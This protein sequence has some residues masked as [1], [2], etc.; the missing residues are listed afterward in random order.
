MISKNHYRLIRLFSLFYLIVCFILSCRGEA[1][2]EQKGLI[3][4]TLINGQR[5][6]KIINIGLVDYSQ[7]LPLV[8]ANGGMETAENSDVSAANLKFQFSQ[9][10]DF[11]HLLKDLINQKIDIAI[12]PYWNVFD[13]SSQLVEKRITVFAITGF[14][15]GGYKGLSTEVSGV[16]SV[17]DLSGKRISC[18]NKSVAAAMAKFQLRLNSISPDDVQWIY[19]KNDTEALAAL[20]SGDADAVFINQATSSA[21]SYRTIAS[22][23][24]WP[25]LM[26]FVVVAGERWLITHASEAKSITDLVIANGRDMQLLRKKY[27]QITPLQQIVPTVQLSSFI[28]AF[29]YDFAAFF[30]LDDTSAVQALYID[31]LE[32]YLPEGF[33][34]KRQYLFSSHINRAFVSHLQINDFSVITSGNHDSFDVCTLFVPIENGEPKNTSYASISATLLRIIP[35]LDS[36]KIRVSYCPARNTGDRYSAESAV[37]AIHK[38]LMKTLSLKYDQINRDYESFNKP[39]QNGYN[40]PYFDKPCVSITVYR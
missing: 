19:V 15:D 12:A 6:K 1:T 34:T 31:T 30:A 23:S 17:R 21:A 14:S 39:F 36:G 38:S 24:A 32:D 9:K 33:S 10:E 5:T 29:A 18:R 11:E 27:E 16:V 4:Q 13:A 3:T 26:P 20:A 28:P 7:A 8:V 22:S 37:D 40:G 35:F 2:L 25:R